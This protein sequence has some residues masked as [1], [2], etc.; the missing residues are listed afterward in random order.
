MK[1]TERLLDA[2]SRAVV[3]HRDYLDTVPNLRSLQVVVWA[4]KHKGTY[5]V[6]MD[7]RLRTEVDAT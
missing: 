5:Q 4:P 6:D 2:I 1:Q 3:E 7:V